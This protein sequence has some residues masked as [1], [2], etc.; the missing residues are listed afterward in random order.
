MDTNKHI[1]VIDD[2]IKIC[3]VISEILMEQGYKVSGF[4]N[5]YD[6]LQFISRGPVDLI[7]LDMCMPGINGVEFIKRLRNR[8]DP[9]PVIILT[10]VKMEN[11]LRKQ[12]ESHIFALIEK[13]VEL[14]RLIQNVNNAVSNGIIIT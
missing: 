7:I 14:N 10:A 2:E 1:V 11:E 8:N 13:P 12:I 6:A 4:T 5:G 3:D 9:T